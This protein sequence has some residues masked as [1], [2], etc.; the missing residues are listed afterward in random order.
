MGMVLI[1]PFLSLAN[2]VGAIT[3]LVV[4]WRILGVCAREPQLGQTPEKSEHR[5]IQKTG[6]YWYLFFIIYIFLS[7]QAFLTEYSHFSSRTIINHTRPDNHFYYF[8]KWF[9]LSI[10]GYV[11]QM[12]HIFGLQ[13]LSFCTACLLWKAP[14]DIRQSKLIYWGFWGQ[15]IGVIFR[16]LSFY[17]AHPPVHW[18]QFI[19]MIVTILIL[20]TLP[21]LALLLFRYKM[22]KSLALK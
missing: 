21:V 14:H 3:L 9:I 15:S 4:I 13:L 6:F 19:E 1:D 11:L 18:V 16:C 5:N 17:F 8:K 2:I 22:K 12:L 7:A 10:S 20:I